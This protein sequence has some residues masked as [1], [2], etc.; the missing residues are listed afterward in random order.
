MNLIFL[1]NSFFLITRVSEKNE[2]KEFCYLIN[3]KHFLAPKTLLS[4]LQNNFNDNVYFI[5]F[6]YLFS[7]LFLC[8]KESY[9]Y[10]PTVL[11]S[12]LRIITKTAVVVR[13]LQTFYFEMKMK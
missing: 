4:Y 5:L 11:K 9:F 8:I 7:Y 2:H 10:K 13:S 3:Y 6:I 1:N 12:K